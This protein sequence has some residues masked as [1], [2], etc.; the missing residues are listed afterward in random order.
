MGLFRLPDFP[1]SRAAMA[2]VVGAVGSLATALAA[3]FTGWQAREVRRTVG[4]QQE[5]RRLLY[6]PY[7]DIS[8]ETADQNTWHVENVVRGVALKCVV[9]T[10][11]PSPVDAQA[12][13]EVMVLGAGHSKQWEL[14][15]LY[16]TSNYIFDPFRPSPARVDIAICED[17]L[18]ALH[19]FG[20]SGFHEVCQR[21]Q[22]SKP[23]WAA[24][25]ELV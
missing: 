7:I 12:I 21:D 10:W 22:K 5:D 3:G 9:F 20:P 4:E 19:R 23:P 18:G 14:W 6:Q 1:F 2:A 17:E 16:P 15:R 25:W 13:S 24:Y 11:L 8:G